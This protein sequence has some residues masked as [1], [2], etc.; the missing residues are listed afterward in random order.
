MENIDW[1]L[2]SGFY[3]FNPF[4]E[5]LL[6]SIRLDTFVEFS[7]QRYEECIRITRAKLMEVRVG[8]RVA[9]YHGFGGE[10]P[11]EFERVAREPIG[12]DNL[13]IWEKVWAKGAGPS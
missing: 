8:S 10:F 1:R 6:E 9:T 5:N 2:F 3:L 11:K 13:E 7:E 4:Y 12:T